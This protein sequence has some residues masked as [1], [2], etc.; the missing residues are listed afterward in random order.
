[1]KKN[2]LILHYIQAKTK[3]LIKELSWGTEDDALTLNTQETA[4]QELVYITNVENDL[5][6]H[7]TNFMK[8]KAPEIKSLQQ[9]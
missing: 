4:H 3:N 5:Q 1:M 8:K 7:S 9:K 6:N 2:R